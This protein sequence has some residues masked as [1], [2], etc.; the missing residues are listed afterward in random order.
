[1]VE[2]MERS[3]GVKVTATTY[4][5]HG[6]NQR[7]SFKAPAWVR[8]PLQKIS[9]GW[10][11]PT[12]Q[13]RCL[14]RHNNNVTAAGNIPLG[15]LPPSQDTLHLMACMQRGRYRRTVQQDRIDAI[16][17]DRALFCFMRTQIMR[18]RGWLRKFL[19][20]KC[21]QGLYFVKVTL[22]RFLTVLK[23]YQLISF[24]VPSPHLRQRRSSR[25]RTL[26][27]FITKQGLRMHPTGNK[28][29]AATK[30]RISL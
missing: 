18:H 11:S 9:N 10:G 27:H 25:P 17:T 8:G 16:T 3:L 4:N 7:Y 23:T 21:V 22:C 19:S 6:T 1:M 20:M 15:N 30:R 14:P 29:R 24:S 12:K 28:S 2:R 5:T 13:S 26:L